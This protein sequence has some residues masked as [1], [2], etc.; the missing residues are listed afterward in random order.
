MCESVQTLIYCRISTLDQVKG[1][2][3]KLQKSACEKYA[4]SREWIVENSYEDVKSGKIKPEDR[5]GFGQLLIDLKKRRYFEDERCQIVLV[6]S[7][8]RI[9][10]D[11]YDILKLIKNLGDY[12]TKIVSVTENF[13]TSTPHGYYYATMLAAMG[14]L[15]RD[16]TLQCLKAGT[17]ER[18]K[19]DGDIGGPMPLGYKRARGT[20]LIVEEKAQIVQ[21]IFHRRYI[22][23][24]FMYEIADEFNEKEVPLPTKR[25]K[26][27]KA[28]VVQRI[29]DNEGKYLGGYRNESKFRWPRI[30]PDD[31]SD[32]EHQAKAKRKSDMNAYRDIKRSKR[33]L[34]QLQASQKG[35]GIPRSTEKV[36]SPQIYEEKVNIQIILNTPFPV[37][38][39][40]LKIV[41]PDP[42][43][44]P[45][46]PISLKTEPKIILSSLDQA[47]KRFSE[48]HSGLSGVQSQLYF[49][50]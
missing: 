2:G 50:S 4:E 19:I 44:V 25:G 28:S 24:R 16:K 3:L 26:V 39:S 1:R 48:T 18:R 41:I 35:D 42:E 29:L 27:W 21:Y 43:G 8:D 32:Q 10:R 15:N 13:D 7:I 12:E 31:F 11:T 37:R 22:D 46:K 40:T 14:Q 45:I 23:F 20:V 49:R 9:G 5:D 36:V 38:T 33:G 6:Y 17:E 34:S 30:L 47:S